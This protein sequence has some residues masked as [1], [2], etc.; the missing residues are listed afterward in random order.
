MVETEDILYWAEWCGESEALRASVWGEAWGAPW[1][2][3]FNG[4]GEW[5]CEEGGGCVGCERCWRIGGL[6]SRSV[7]S[8]PKSSR[9]RLSRLMSVKPKARNSLITA[10]ETKQKQLG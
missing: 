1:G 5:G 9:T 8:S 2:K 6:L 7:K 3:W 4:W 10:Y